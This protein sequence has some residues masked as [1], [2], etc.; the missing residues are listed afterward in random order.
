MKD[1][2][3]LKKIALDANQKLVKDQTKPIDCIG[4]KSPKKMSKF[5]KL[6]K[7]LK[8]GKDPTKN[9]VDRF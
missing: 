8:K 7:K 3:E 1:L 2:G 5:K 6:K 4:D 9:T